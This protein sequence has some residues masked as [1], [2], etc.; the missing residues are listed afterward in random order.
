MKKEKN[1]GFSL[2]ELIIVIAIMAIL[3]GILAPAYL[4]YVEKSKISSDLNLVDS[5]SK[6]LTYA[7]ADEKVSGDDETVAIVDA[8]KDAGNPMKLEELMDH[9]SSLYTKEV[10]ETLGW[11]DCNRTTYLNYLKAGHGSGAEIYIVYRAT[12]QEPFYVW[13]SETD[14]TGKKN[15]DS[16]TTTLSTIGDCISVRR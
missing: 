6:A 14:R 13:I 7:T 15:Y 9:S 4:R 8:M 3:I 11:D 1:G 10:L 16:A 12:L 2:V 5:I